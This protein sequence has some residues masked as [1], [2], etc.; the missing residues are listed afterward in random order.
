MRYL[1]KLMAMERSQK[2]NQKTVML[3]RACWQPTAGD[4]AQTG[5]SITLPMR[6]AIVCPPKRCVEVL[7]PHPIPQHRG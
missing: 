3:L 6:G 1:A 2:L 7:T 5:S 4:N